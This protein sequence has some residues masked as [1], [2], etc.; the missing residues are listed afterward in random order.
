M[1][2]CLNEVHSIF[3]REI[4]IQY[5]VQRKLI[6]Q[7][8][9]IDVKGPADKFRAGIWIYFLSFFQNA[10]FSDIDNNLAL[11]PTSYS[12]TEEMTYYVI[13]RD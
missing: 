12:K 9:A 8:R 10:V 2:T 13:G 1:N 4:R 6:T 3:Q 11:D 5:S 7:I